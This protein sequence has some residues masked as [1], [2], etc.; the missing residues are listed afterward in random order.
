M[1]GVG[2][3]YNICGPVEPCVD[4]GIFVMGGGGG[5]GSRPDSHKTAWTRFYFS[6]QLILQFTEGS[7]GFIAEKTFPRIQRGS[8]HFPEGGP[9]FSM[10][11]GVQM[12]ISIETHIT[13]EFPGWGPDP[14]SPT[15]SAHE[16][17][18]GLFTLKRAS[19]L[20]KFNCFSRLITVY[21]Y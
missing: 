1:G 14:L 12:L 7:N 21:I 15:G 10:G 5:G 3:G 17:C 8:K 4:L 20:N 18:E 19:S 16:N 6:P 2:E 11:G 9:T 13:C